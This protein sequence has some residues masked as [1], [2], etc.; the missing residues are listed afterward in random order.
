MFTLSQENYLL[1]RYKK[2]ITRNGNLLPFFLF[3]TLF[4][5][6][7]L[8]TLRKHIIFIFSVRCL[9]TLTKL[10][11][12]CWH[13]IKSLV[14]EKLYSNR[15]KNLYWSLDH[16]FLLF[17]ASTNYVNANTPRADEAEN[18]RNLI[19]GRKSKK[20]IMDFIGKCCIMPGDNKKNL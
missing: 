19:I 14:T 1:R 18:Y 3:M 7:T 13:S 9:I 12:C 20:V 6:N 10:N 15:G 11:G 16:F 17:S 4:D 2:Y 5:R 8:N